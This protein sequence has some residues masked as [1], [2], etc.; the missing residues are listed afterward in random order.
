MLCVK[1]NM[2]LM[3]P[4]SIEIVMVESK[5]QM[6]DK[7]LQNYSILL[8]FENQEIIIKL[9]PAKFKLLISEQHRF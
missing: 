2:C 7:R 8:V 3:L 1:H 6:A 5:T 4:C 9:I